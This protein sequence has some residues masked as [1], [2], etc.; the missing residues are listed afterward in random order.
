M[1]LNFIKHQIAFE[2]NIVASFAVSSKSYKLVGNNKFSGGTCETK[3]ID[4]LADMHSQI[5]L[6]K[7]KLIVFLLKYISCIEFT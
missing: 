2:W 1:Q 5:Q 6:H 3:Q 7:F 4:K